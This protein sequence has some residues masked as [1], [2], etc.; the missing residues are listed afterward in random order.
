[1]TFWRADLHFLLLFWR[2]WLGMKNNFWMPTKKGWK[3]GSFSKY[4]NKS[5]TKLYTTAWR[6][7]YVLINR[8]FKKYQ[9]IAETW[10]V[11]RNSRITRNLYPFGICTI[12]GCTHCTA[13]SS[14]P[15]FTFASRCA[16]SSNVPKWCS[17][18]RRLQ[19]APNVEAASGPSRLWPL[20]QP[21]YPLVRIPYAH[22]TPSLPDMPVQSVE[23]SWWAARELPL[24]CTPTH[25]PSLRLGKLQDHVS[26]CQSPWVKI[27]LPLMPLEIHS[28]TQ[29]SAISQKPVISRVK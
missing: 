26:C 20:S 13:M 10:P 1:M 16:V 29:S 8:K 23:A 14:M 3:S 28:T 21:T 15:H 6:N 19:R 5:Q 9:K 12:Y 17:T 4:P 18:P 27:Q 22:P 2:P 7:T 25:H 24:G 11:S